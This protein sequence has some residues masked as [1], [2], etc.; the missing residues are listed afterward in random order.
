MLS[1]VP[2]ALKWLD[3]MNGDDPKRSLVLADQW[4][5]SKQ[6]GWAHQTALAVLETN[7]LEVKLKA[8]SEKICADVEAQAT[9]KLP[10]H[11][12]SN[13]ENSQQQSGSSNGRSLDINL[14]R[15]K[16]ASELVQEYQSN[17]DAQREK[18]HETL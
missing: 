15:T 16:A 10:S 2:D 9:E 12:R 11:Q 14:V 8:A 7:D 6:Y 1:P 4:A 5:R 13:G 3:A 18:S 17:R